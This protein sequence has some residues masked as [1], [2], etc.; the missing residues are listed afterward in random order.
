MEQT[1][2]LSPQAL[3]VAPML[4]ITYAEMLK[5]ATG[6]R[7]DYLDEMEGEY[8]QL[9][10]VPEGLQAENLVGL[11]NKIIRGEASQEIL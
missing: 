8:G 7:A 9:E 1:S 4:K 2:N 6:D 3:K 10:T 5:Q 11:A